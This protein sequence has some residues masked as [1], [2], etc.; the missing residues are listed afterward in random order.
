[1]E[2]TMTRTVGEVMTPAPLSLAAG[3][4]AA[5]AA[6]VMKAEGIGDVIVLDEGVVCG[7]V[8]DRDL[9]VRVLAEGRDPQSTRLGEVC[10]RE[11]VTLGPDDDIA[12]A[13][14]LIR[15]H[16]VRRIPI[17]EQGRPVGILTIGDLA[18]ERDPTSALA[19]VSLAAPNT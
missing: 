8:T 1:M 13:V 4:T 17:V 3:R 14:A 9:V 5:E 19:D 12:E 15:T 16:A 11:L 6:A 2:A 7:L 18:V 10:S